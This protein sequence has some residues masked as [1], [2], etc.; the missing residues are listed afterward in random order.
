MTFCTFSASLLHWYND[1]EKSIY[2]K[3]DLIVSRVTGTVYW[4]VGVYVITDLI[5]YFIITQSILLSYLISVYT[6]KHKNDIWIVWHINFHICTTISQFYILF[7]L[8]QQNSN[9]VLTKDNVF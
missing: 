6:Y 4:L 2:H 3:I 9:F 8:Q 5:L 7:N 1:A